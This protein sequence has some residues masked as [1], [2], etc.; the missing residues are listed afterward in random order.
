MLYSI[1]Q[2]KSALFLHETERSFRRKQ[3]ADEG[4]LLHGESYGESIRDYLPESGNY[5]SFFSFR[6]AIFASS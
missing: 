3:P 2:L 6:S 5:I 1:A 4:E